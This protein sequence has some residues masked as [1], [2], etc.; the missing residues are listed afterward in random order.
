MLI[1][2]YNI[3]NITISKCLNYHPKEEELLFLPMCICVGVSVYECLS[4]CKHMYVSA[5]VY[6][7]MKNSVTV[8]GLKS[9]GNRMQASEYN[10]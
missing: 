4:V 2:D 10:S 1:H 9:Q 5:C 7:S 6:I 3:R 8:G